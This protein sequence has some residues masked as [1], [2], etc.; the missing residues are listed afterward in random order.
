MRIFLRHEAKENNNQNNLLILRS[1]IHWLTAL[2]VTTLRPKEVDFPAF[3]GW[4]SR[5]R[6]SSCRV[7]NMF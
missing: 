6:T 3:S 7:G 5:R 4:P 2:H 1:T